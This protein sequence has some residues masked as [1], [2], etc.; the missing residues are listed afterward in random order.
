MN[1]TQQ[2]RI[3]DVPWSEDVIAYVLEASYLRK[4]DADLG[5]ELQMLR[6]LKSVGIGLENFGK[7][8]EN[9]LSDPCC[10]TNQVSLS[11]KDQLEDSW[12]G[13]QSWQQ[14]MTFY[15]VKIV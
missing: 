2:A 10:Q 1:A 4:E 15:Q 14:C 11:V 13:R 6:D 5:D 12:N 7:I 3:L 8:A 9:S